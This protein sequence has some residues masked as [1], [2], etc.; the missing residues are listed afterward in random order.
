MVEEAKKHF[1]KVPRIGASIPH[2]VLGEAA[3]GVVLLGESCDPFSVEAVR[4]SMGSI[5]ARFLRENKVHRG[6]A[7][8]RASRRPARRRGCTSPHWTPGC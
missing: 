4:A 7:P 5:F 2:P 6:P 1:F 8:P 3:A